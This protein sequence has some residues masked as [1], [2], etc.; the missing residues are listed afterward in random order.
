MNLVFHTKDHPEAN[1]RTPRAGEVGHELSFPLD[2]GRQLTV[3]IG[4]EGLRRLHNVII[5]DTLN[6][7][8]PCPDC[9]GDSFHQSPEGEFVCSFCHWDTHPPINW[10]L[11][12][13]ISDEIPEPERVS[14][15]FRDGKLWVSLRG[16]GDRPVQEV[17]GG[18]INPRWRKANP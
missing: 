4:P 14:A 7:G 16:V 6:S 1:G 5:A 8:E 9:H 3:K 17:H 2:D 15:F 18:L 13:L 10:G 12:D 11:Y